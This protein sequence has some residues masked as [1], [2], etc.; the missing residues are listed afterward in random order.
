ME[1]DKI[2]LLKPKL[3]ELF[4]FLYH[5][6]KYDK[7]LM[8]SIRNGLFD[9]SIILI[10]KIFII[11]L[12]EKLYQV[13]SDEILVAWE[14]KYGEKKKPK[15]FKKGNL[16]WPNNIDDDEVI[17]F[18]YELYDID[19]NILKIAT[20][21][22]VK[23]NSAAHV[24]DVEFDLGGVDRFLDEILILCK[25]IQ[26]AHKEYLATIDIMEIDT[27]LVS[28]KMS[29]KDIEALVNRII[30]SLKNSSS[31]NESTQI[32]RKII[33]LKNHLSRDDIKSI[34]DSIKENSYGALY[35]QILEASGAESFI[36]ELYETFNEPS[37]EWNDFA[38]F[39]I[40]SNNLKNILPSYDWLF[41]IV[42]KEDT[43]NEIKD[44]DD[45]EI[46]F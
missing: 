7:Q 11:F 4:S 6:E 15:G 12:Y 24:S 36:K 5:R 1:N 39:L 21:L 44:I 37:P 28:K 23:R 8:L 14:S 27:M 42:K 16:F 33:N 20:P 17:N 38:E 2:L 10:W 18:L 31:F 43:I 13:P 9:F 26:E 25:K 35:H 22:S 29:H 34:L 19:K 40:E 3:K 45:I 41:K 30:I 46:P 32:R